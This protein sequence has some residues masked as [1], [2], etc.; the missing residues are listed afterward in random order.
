MADL[1]EQ[2]TDFR[3]LPNRESQIDNRQ[4]KIPIPSSGLK[5]I[6]GQ[7]YQ[8]CVCAQKHAFF[9]FSLQ[10]IKK[11]KTPVARGFQLKKWSGLSKPAL[12]TACRR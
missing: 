6:W 8:L 4:S 3:C 12:K 7:P 10:G 2:N 11:K 1:F 5:Q 9:N